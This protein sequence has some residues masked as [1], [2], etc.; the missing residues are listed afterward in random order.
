MIREK[1]FGIN[2]EFGINIEYEEKLEGVVKGYVRRESYADSIIYQ[3]THA[4]YIRD[5]PTNLEAITEIIYGHVWKNETIPLTIL[6]G[7]SKGPRHKV[8]DS[9]DKETLIHI[10][11]IEKNLA[12]LVKFSILFCN[13]H[14]FVCNDISWGATERYKQ[15]LQRL[16][17]ET[18]KYRI[19]GTIETLSEC[20]KGDEIYLEGNLDSLLMCIEKTARTKAKILLQDEEYAKKCMT[21]TMK[22]SGWYKK[23]KH[24]K[25]PPQQFEKYLAQLYIQTEIDFLYRTGYPYVEEM[26]QR[27]LSKIFVSFSN[28]EIQKPIAEAADVPMLF[29]W[30]REG[31]HGE[32]PW[33]MDGKK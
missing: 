30:P 2:S 33:Y 15:S 27:H 29:F 12:P 20:L 32:V 4:S 28:P 6:W 19:G 26:K 24:L 17:T 8:A 13:S 21:A 9:A 18:K 22:H 25:H 5:S 7:G 23:F 10:K 3:L 11:R 31:R 1:I 16:Q 14:H